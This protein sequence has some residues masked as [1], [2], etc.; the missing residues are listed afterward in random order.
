MKMNLRKNNKPFDFYNIKK[1]FKLTKNACSK[2]IKKCS[3]NK[4]STELDYLM[5]KNLKPS[6]KISVK[7]QLSIKESIAKHF[8]KMGV[9]GRY[10]SCTKFNEYLQQHVKIERY[11]NYPMLDQQRIE[12]VKAINVEV[13]IRKPKQISYMDSELKN[14]SIKQG[15]Y[16]LNVSFLKQ[17]ILV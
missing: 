9:T 11:F 2:K 1:A 8:F 6:R 14:K 15:N 12:K 4:I 7:G 10:T 3:F 17:I 16:T 5:I 13:M